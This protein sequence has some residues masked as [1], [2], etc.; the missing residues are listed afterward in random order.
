MPTLKVLEDVPE[1]DVD[2]VI[3]DFES[4]GCM[5]EKEEQA[6]GMYTV[7]AT[8]PDEQQET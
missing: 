2:Q 5:V 3:E 4:E 7:R 1:V 8:C 6:N